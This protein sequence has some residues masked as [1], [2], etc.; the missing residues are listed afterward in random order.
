MKA[1]RMHYWPKTLRLH[2]L[3]VLCACLLLV[4]QTM[5]IHAQQPP[6]ESS[7]Y[8]I[9]PDVLNSG[10]QDVSTSSE[11][12]LSDSLGEPIVGHGDSAE[13]MLDSGYRQPSGADFLSMSCA[14]SATIGT[15]VGTGQKTGS[16]VC[17]IGTDGASGYSLSWAILSGSGGMNTGSLISQFN[18][19][20][21]P[22][23]PAIANTP[24]AWS[25]AAT[26]A[27][28]GAR[29]ASA[30]TDSAAEWGTDGLSEQWLNVSA[31]HR[32]IITRSTPTSNEGSTEVLQFRSEVGSLKTQP[33]GTYQA[34][35]TL[36]VV[37]Y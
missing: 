2:R 16:G 26:D 33:L 5:I 34:V 31:T 10:G 3:F 37:G 7:E 35:I 36:T 25:V 20:I 23:S 15:V 27:A 6:T 11:Y 14:S 1:R 21:P 9:K 12:F 29:L 22:M 4:L 28:W 17:V 24:E 30:S 8:R 19:T 18:D 32:T 13:Y